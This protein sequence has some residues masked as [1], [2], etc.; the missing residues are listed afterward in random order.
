M[1][2][3]WGSCVL[4][5]AIT[6]FAPAHLLAQDYPSRTVTIVVPLAAGTGMDIV[7]RSYAEKLTSR[8]GQ[9]VIIDNKPGG[10]FILATR[11]VIAAPA[12]GHTLLVAASV[13]LSVN[14]TLFK[15]LPYHPEKDLVPI[16]LYLTTPFVLVVNPAVPAMSFDE[17]INYA[18]NQSTPVSYSS[19]AGGG[20]PHYGVEFVRQRFGLQFAHVPYK[21]SPQSIQDVAAG[22]VTF[23]LAEVGASLAL[24]QAGKLRALAVSSKQRVPALAD[25]PTLAEASGLSDLEIVAWHALVARSGTPRPIIDRLNDEM[26]RIM[27]DPVMHQR[28][29]GMGLIP[30]EP[31]SPAETAH[32]ISAETVRWRSILQTIGLAGSQ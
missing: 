27:G 23:A 29:A 32:Y 22:H 25:V 21:S 17:F 26:K 24:I 10:A 30:M 8:L 3:A 6:G 11:S 28:I 18:R 13:S 1:S 12:D 19:P 14:Q 20:V 15:Q 16:S 31:P 4:A 2:K 7:A 9:P 5:A